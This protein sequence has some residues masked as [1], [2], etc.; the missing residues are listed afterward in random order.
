MRLLI[1]NCRLLGKELC[2]VVVDGG[3]IAEVHRG[4][5]P[6]V[7]AGTA[8]LD[9]NEGALFPGLTDTHC[10]P[11]EYGWLKRSVD[12]RGASNITAVRLRLSARL[13]RSSAGEWVTGMGW[14]QEA[15]AERRMP[16]REDVDDLTRRNPVVLSRVCGHIALLNTA[17]IE[18]LGLTDR[19][20][21]E[22]ERDASGALTGIV[23]ESALAEVL[24][25]VPK[26]PDRSASDLQSVEAEALR[27]GLVALHCIVSPDGY[28]EEL[29]ALAALKSSGSLSLRYR[30]YIPPEA[31][32]FVEE[33]GLRKSLADG[34]A[35]INGVKVYADGSLGAR[36]AA[37]WEPYSDEPANSGLLRHSDEE[38]QGIVE[39][40][41]A[42]GYQVIIHAIGDRAVDQAVEALSRVAGGRNPKR[43]RVEHA[44]MLPRSIRTK[45]AKHGIRA[46]VQPA[47]I[48]SDTWALS[49]LGPDRVR[50]LYP[51][52]SMLSEGLLV[53]GGSDS[54]IE[55]LSPVLGV[56][57]AM[58][59]GEASLESLT[60]DEAIGLY[61]A[62][63]GSNGFDDAGGLQEGGVADLTL[64]DSDVAG[65]HPAMVRKVGV[66]AVVA[67]G[68]LAY[69]ALGPPSTA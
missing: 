56:W 50:D 8:R 21:P 33:R 20:G 65:L 69:S 11:F 2:S 62:S 24:A 22:W 48:T 27:F 30:A 3:R 43:H 7:P 14:D 41:D 68:A 45:M 9:A 19:T 53:S 57:S 61:T 18:S 35:R 54:P 66:A 5:A 23:K 15:M 25:R 55:S 36:T 12:L 67:S 31:L 17:A 46:S 16:S 63:A 6:G 10:H 64:L 28:K 44:S 51:L 42:Q 39:R 59:R 52:K 58:V 37:L 13:A 4:G 29:E 38:L 1:E 49:R 47:F 60:F 26:G 40:A 34:R 32:A